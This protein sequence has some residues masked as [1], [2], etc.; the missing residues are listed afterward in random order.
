MKIKIEQYHKYWRYCINDLYYIQKEFDYAL[1]Y[2][3]FDKLY[4]SKYIYFT[5]LEIK[6]RFKRKYI[7]KDWLE[8]IYNQSP[9]GYQW[10][11]NNW[12]ENVFR[13]NIHYSDKQELK[14]IVNKI[15]NVKLI[16][17]EK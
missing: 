11:K 14:T 2:L 16:N 10:L 15:I 9:E 12:G 17:K 4:K 7:E 8:D 13:M 3:D 1:K 6:Q 5:D